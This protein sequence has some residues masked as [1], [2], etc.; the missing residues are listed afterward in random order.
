MAH[1]LHVYQTA[2]ACISRYVYTMVL[3]HYAKRELET[4]LYVHGIRV[5]AALH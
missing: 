4:L 3:A 5:L 2:H 1:I